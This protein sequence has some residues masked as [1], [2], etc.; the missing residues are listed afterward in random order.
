MLK[1]GMIGIGGMGRGHV[2]IYERLM[3]EGAPVRLVALCDVDPR[4]L[5]GKSGGDFNIDIGKDVGPVEGCAKYLDY[6]EMIANEELDYVDLAVP[7]YLHAPIAIYAMNAGLHVLSE[8]PMAIS[9]EAC[10]EMVETAQRTGK[11]LMVAQ[12]LRFW[13]AYQLLRECIEDGRFGKVV[14]AYFYRGGGSPQWTWNEWMKDA[15]LSGGALLDQHVHD[16]DTINWLFGMPRAVSCVGVKGLYSTGYDALSTNYIYPGMVVNAQDDWT[17]NGDGYGFEMTYRV[18]FEKAMIALDRD[19]VTVYP[20]E[21]KKFRP[22][23]S[24]EQGYYNEI[25]YFIDAVLHDKP[26]TVASPRSTMDSIRIAQAEMVSADR[27]GE[28]IAIE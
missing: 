17:I 2:A 3:K 1:V 12:C 19:G 14:C 21:G 24:T 6:K 27:G 28:L 25:R 26:I 13:P 18:N 16:V 22:E 5:E 4:K 10:A 8:K 23:L 20:V 15:S 9:V 7:T 11:K